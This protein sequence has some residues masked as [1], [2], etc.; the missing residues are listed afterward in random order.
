MDGFN[1]WLKRAKQ[2]I[3]ELEDIQNKEKK[4]KR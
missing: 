3:S 4:K 1:S 2:K